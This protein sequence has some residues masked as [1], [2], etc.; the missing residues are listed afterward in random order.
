MLFQIPVTF[1]R[2]IMMRQDADAFGL[3]DLPAKPVRQ[4]KAMGT[5]KR[6][7]TMSI[8]LDRTFFAALVLGASMG[9]G[10]STTSFADDALIAKGEKVFKKCKACHM[11][12][13]NAKNKVGPHLNGAM[14]RKVG[15]LE[16]YK[17]SK[18]MAAK[19]EEGLVWNDDTMDAYLEAPRKYV[20]KTKMAFA[21][22]RKE[23]DR[24]AIIAYLKTYS[25]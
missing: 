3:D 9:L 4:D 21:G 23:A 22:L 6:T 13:E 15:G 20:P 19:G 18:A 10:F 25:E 5:E 14:G 2:Q 16:D 7:L 24:E 1:M 8:K 11:V 12:G 17:Y